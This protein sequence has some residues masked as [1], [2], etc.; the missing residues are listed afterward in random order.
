MGVNKP[1]MVPV[2]R[3]DL[4]SSSG[5]SFMGVRTLGFRM[6]IITD[7]KLYSR[8]RIIIFLTVVVMKIIIN[9]TFLSSRNMFSDYKE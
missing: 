9:F 7:I 6:D 4:R 3:A 8:T 2:L 1:S 5:T